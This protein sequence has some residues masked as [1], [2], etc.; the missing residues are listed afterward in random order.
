MRC[1]H[2]RLA[3]TCSARCLTANHASAAGSRK[4]GVFETPPLRSHHQASLCRN[5]P[6]VQRQT[7]I[8]RVKVVYLCYLQTQRSPWLRGRRNSA[9]TWKATLRRICGVCHTLFHRANFSFRAAFSA[10]SAQ[11]LTE[12]LKAAVLNKTSRTT[13]IPENMPPRILGVF[14]GQ[15]AQWA[16]M[17]AKL[18]ESSTVFRSAF[19]RMQDSLDEL[20]VKDGRPSWSL[21]EELRAPPATSHIGEAAVLQPICTA[22]QVALV[23]MIS[24]AGVQFLGVVGHS[25]GEIAAAYTAGYL[26]AHDAIRIAYFR[27]LHLKKA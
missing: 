19:S 15:G 14:T 23:D 16:A 22:V 2:V 4:S 18:Y 17:G 26:N 10:T 8:R 25:S 9:I 6:N 3:P 12:K 1:R 21:I 20:S 11:Q 24:A 7:L 27:G 13:S 5:A